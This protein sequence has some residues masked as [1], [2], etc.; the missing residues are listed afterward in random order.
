[1][2]SASHSTLLSYHAG[3]G[4]GLPAPGPGSLQHQR[5][6]AWRALPPRPCAASGGGV[7]SQRERHS[8]RA[9]V[10][11]AA[12]PG[13][14]SSALQLPR[15]PPSGRWAAAARAMSGGGMPLDGS[16]GPGGGGSSSSSGGGSGGLQSGQQAVPGTGAPPAVPATGGP[17]PEQLK[18]LGSQ[19]WLSML[20]GSLPLWLAQGLVSLAR[21]LI[22]CGEVLP[23]FVA[24]P[25][26]EALRR[27]GLV[28]AV[29]LVMMVVVNSVDSL[30]L[31]LYLLRSRVVAA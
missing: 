29:S 5:C 28:L 10:P 14:G 19:N 13:P 24:P 15:F 7:H 26:P 4:P 23:Q 11:D 8:G 18:R 9:D 17:S 21:F 22:S 25:L 6:S 1:M 27:A 2:L 20:L 30:W 31:Y 3:C 16:S 12:G